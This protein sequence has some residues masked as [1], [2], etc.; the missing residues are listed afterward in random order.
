MNWALGEG[1]ITSQDN[2][3][4]FHLI[5]NHHWREILSISISIFSLAWG[6][7]SYYR[8]KKN[9]SL[10]TIATMAY[11]FSTLLFV[12][13]RILCFQMF[14]YFLGPGKFVHAIVIVIIHVFLM[15]IIHYVFSY[16]V[17]QYKSTPIDN[18]TISKTSFGLQ[19]KSIY[20]CF[21]NGL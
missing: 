5:V 18:G 14:A 21:I 13:S 1:S 4:R 7:T 9:F 10:G 8:R 12:V 20:G 3:G 6:Y 17:E 11:F 16:S 15:S 19:F 2:D